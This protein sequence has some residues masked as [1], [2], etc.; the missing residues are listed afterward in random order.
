MRLHSTRIL[1]SAALAALFLWAGSAQ[2]QDKLV[3]AEGVLELE[4]AADEG[5]KPLY[6]SAY[7]SPYENLDQR[8]LAALDQAKPGS[9]VYMS[10][11]SISYY[12]YPKKFRE[13]RDR[14]VKLKLNLYEKEAVAQGKT[15]DDELIAE[16]FDVQLIPN[17]R[18]PKGQGSMH[19]KFTIVNNELV[20]TG[21]ANLSASASL[22]NHEHIVVTLQKDLARR[23]RD[24]FN[25]QRRA[26]KAMHAAMTKEEWDTYNTSYSDPFP[27]DWSE[28]GASSR[29]G[30]IAAALRKIDRKTTNPLVSAQTWFSPEDELDERCREQLRKAKKSIKVAMYTF[31]NG[32]ASDLRDMARKGVEVWVIADDHQQEMDAAE[33]VNGILEAEPNIHYL[34]IENHLGLYSALHHKYAVIDDEVVLGGS[35]NWTGSATNYNDE[36]LIVVHSK[37]LGARFAQD[38]AM[39]HAEYDP[40]G[41]QPAAPPAAG[42]SG[43]VLLSVALPFSVARDMHVFARV[44]VDGAEQEVELRHSGSTGENWLGS[45]DL[46][47]GAKATWQVVISKKA[48]IIGVLEGDGSESWSEPAPLHETTVRADGLAQ[49][50]HDRWHGA[51]PGF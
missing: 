42:D 32:L 27:A 36:N 33:W 3:V 4:R 23:Y 21:S 34:R 50:V 13:L 9:T 26:A 46:P 30:K 11:Y 18:N 45:T 41:P 6:A 51:A 49:I 16:G 10:Y 35:Y 5:G 15:I 2:A 20:V 12:D 47:R 37:P 17:V 19:T 7:F 22:A 8:V 43:R 40:E 24:E 25:E 31:V 14:G 39:M 44:T 29:A 48:S 28:G 1:P 38:F